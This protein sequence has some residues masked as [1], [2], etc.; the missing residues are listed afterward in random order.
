MCDFTCP[1]ESEEDV[2]PG[3]F[4]LDSDYEGG[5]QEDIKNYHVQ[6]KMSEVEALRVLRRE[7]KIRMS[8]EYFKVT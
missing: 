3:G 1:D 7:A 6:I 8:P 2:D 4:M 5:S